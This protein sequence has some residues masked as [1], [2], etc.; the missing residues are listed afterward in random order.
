MKIQSDANCGRRQIIGKNDKSRMFT[1]GE[2]NVGNNIGEETQTCSF[3][4]VS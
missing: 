4:R 3:D 2:N 1:T